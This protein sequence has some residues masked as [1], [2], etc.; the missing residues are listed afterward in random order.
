MGSQKDIE[1]VR[2][3]VTSGGIL[4]EAGAS[5]VVARRLS[6]VPTSFDRSGPKALTRSQNRS[7]E[8]PPRQERGFRSFWNW[9]QR[10]G[11]RAAEGEYQ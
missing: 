7:S 3:E 6:S 2:A 8:P 4:M 10:V 9:R 11:A 1:T 5:A